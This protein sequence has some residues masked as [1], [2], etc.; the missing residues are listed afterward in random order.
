MIATMASV[1]R[2]VPRRRG[3]TLVELLVVIAII[4]ILMALTLS[5][6][7]HARESARRLQCKNNLKQLGLAML[8][9]EETHKRLPT[10]GWGYRWVGDPRRGSG[11]RQ[12]GGW[13]F[14]ILPFLEQ[15][16]VFDMAAEASSD[17]DRRTKLAGML[18]T[19]LG[20]LHC[21]S[22]RSPTVYPTQWQAYNTDPTKLVAK[23]DYAASAGDVFVDVGSGPLT[24]WQGDS[25]AYL[26]PDYRGT[27]ICY[28]R[29]EV[30]L[31]DIRDGASN[32]YMIGEKNIPRRHYGT[33]DHRG[34]DQSMYSGDD[35][36]TLR[37]TSPT[38]TPLNDRSGDMA[39]ARFGAA[40]SSGCN[41]AFCDGSVRSVSYTIEDGVHQNLGNRSDGQVVDASGI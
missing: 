7:Q 14:C 16:N 35:F 28:L 12:P 26:W 30:R 17:R 37:W 25:S 9:H 34:D 38:W 23:T 6:V 22:R 3:F 10:G 27:G 2:D 5:A 21:P 13:T 1:A 15:Q 40:H 31:A 18:Q 24:L 29:S 20:V 33:G 32:T 11:K 8:V 19:S 4:G 41:F 39:E 36:D